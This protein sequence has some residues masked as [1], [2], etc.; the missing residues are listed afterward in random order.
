M[1]HGSQRRHH[2]TQLGPACVA[3]EHAG[4]ERVEN[5]LGE[6][7]TKPALTEFGDGFLAIRVAGGLPEFGRQAR[8][9]G[10]GQIAGGQESQR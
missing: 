2:E 7:G 4:D 3:R 8:A 6:F 1:F 10:Q 9:A 5:A